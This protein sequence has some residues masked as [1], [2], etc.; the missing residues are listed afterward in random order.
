LWDSITTFWISRPENIARASRKIRQLQVADRI[1]FQ[2]PNTFITS[3]TESAA[4]FLG[5]IGSKAIT[6]VLTS[7]PKMGIVT[8]LI[9]ETFLDN[10][11]GLKIAPSILQPLLTKKVDVRIT[12]VG[13]Q[14]FSV[15]ID[16]QKDCETAADWRHP[17][18]VERNRHVIH[19][20]PPELEDKCRQIVSE[21]GLA[22]GAIDLVL[23]EAGDYVF[24]ELNPNGQWLWLQR[25]TGV[26]IA[27]A[28]ALN[29]VRHC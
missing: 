26:P 7:D 9:D 14:V 29:L 18:I 6:K 28:I 8:Q 11:G 1:G 21:F 22:F 23:N 16:S 3:N 15:A 4:R 27:E 13:E 12:V 17:K 20:L 25:L 5:S 24:L 2:I 10:L 19:R